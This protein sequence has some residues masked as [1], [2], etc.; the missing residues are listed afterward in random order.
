MSRERMGMATA[1]PAVIEI[2]RRD[3]PKLNWR[4]STAPAPPEACGWQKPIHAGHA[5][6]GY[7]WISPP[8]RSA[9]RS[10][11]GSTSGNRAGTRSG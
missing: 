1:G 9:R 3:H 6:I 5:T 8:R 4:S 11:W 2:A 10:R 7:S